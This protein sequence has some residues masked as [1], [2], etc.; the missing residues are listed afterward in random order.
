MA[1]ADLYAVAVGGTGSVLI[2]NIFS[3][4]EEPKINKS[5]AYVY[6][7]SSAS[8]TTNLKDHSARA[9]TK[10]WTPAMRWHLA[11]EYSTNCGRLAEVES[12]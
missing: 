12:R 4:F 5:I 7:S 11:Q 3:N 9:L 8:G 10:A 6:S 1:G 2:S